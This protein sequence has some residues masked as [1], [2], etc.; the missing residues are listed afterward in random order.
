MLTDLERQE[1]K[2]REVLF[3][4]EVL[5]P[6]ARTTLMRGI[7][8]RPLDAAGR[9]IEGQPALS[10]SG[11]FVWLRN[12]ANE[13]PALI[14]V[15]PGRL[16]FER[17][18]VKVSAKAEPVAT[19]D[20]LI[21]VPMRPSLA[22]P[23]AEG[24][25]MVRGRIWEGD[26]SDPQGVAGARVQLAFFDVAANDWWP[27]VLD[28]PLPLGEALTDVSGAFAVFFRQPF[29][30]GAADVSA[31]LVRV[32]LQVTRPGTPVTLMTRTPD[33][34]LDA[35]AYGAATEDARTRIP[36]GRPY[37]HDLNLKWTPD[38]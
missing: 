3:A 18:R 32:R 36:L 17:T 22:Y 12:R 10:H 33:T 6:V 28:D 21:T 25:T 5:D 7:E 35:A 16:P 19:A 31:G 23:F 27:T 38:Q 11:R 34:W 24:V 15:R 4:V 8:V 29:P 30:H 14:E 13:R 9:L 2:G 1:I 37:P 20:R 26:K